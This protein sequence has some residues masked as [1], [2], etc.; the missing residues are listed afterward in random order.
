[1]R[2][3]TKF[4]SALAGA[5]AVTATGTMLT[6][7]ASPKFYPDDPVWIEH[8]TQDAS[9]IKPLEV[10][11]FVDLTSN[12]VAGRTTS[13]ARRAGNINTVGEVPDSSWFSNR[14]GYRPM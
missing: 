10:D 3:T 7:A 1:M 13:S 4:L 6:S 2:A 5:L 8:D 14:L 9:N 11:L 12:L